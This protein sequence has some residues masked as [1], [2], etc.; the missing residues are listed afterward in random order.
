[1]KDKPRRRGGAAMPAPPKGLTPREYELLVMVAMS[2]DKTG[3]QPSYRQIA[4][5]FGWTSLTYITQMVNNLVK[6]R[7]VSKCGARGLSY[8]WRAYLPA[9][10]NSKGESH[11]S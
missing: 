11:G 10:T 6:K 2:I 1:M 5:T 7:E 3:V 4:K 8:N 9:S